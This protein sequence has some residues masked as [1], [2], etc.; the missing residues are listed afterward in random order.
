MK[1]I[2]LRTEYLNDPLGIDMQHPRLFWNCMDGTTQSAYQLLAVTD[3]ETVW[4]SGKVRSSSMH[5][6]YPAALASRQQVCWRVRLWDENDEPG[7]WSE[8]AFFE[9]GLLYPADWCLRSH[10][11]SKSRKH[12]GFSVSANTAKGRNGPIRSW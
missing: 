8:E 7:E 6:D 1:A 9:M 3:G 12:P 10:R 11:F 5:A 2:R 4:D